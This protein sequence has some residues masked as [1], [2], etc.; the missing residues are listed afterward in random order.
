MVELWFL[1]SAYSPIKHYSTKFL[2]NI[3]DCLKVIE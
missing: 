1:F 3:D 2:E